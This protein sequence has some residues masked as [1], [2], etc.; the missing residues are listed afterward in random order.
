MDN[1][2]VVKSRPQMHGRR[3]RGAHMTYPLDGPYLFL[4]E[5]SMC[6]AVQ[7]IG[8]NLQCLHLF[9]ITSHC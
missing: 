8:V 9:Y 5:L 4:S 3:S 1:L 2:T 6:E 7:R